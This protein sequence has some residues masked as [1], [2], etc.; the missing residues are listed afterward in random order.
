M[1]F[2]HTHSFRYYTTSFKGCQGH[3]QEYWCIYTIF[4]HLCCANKQAIFAMLKNVYSR[5][6]CLKPVNRSQNGYNC[7]VVK[8]A[9]YNMY[10]FSSADLCKLSKLVLAHALLQY[11]NLYCFGLWSVNCPKYFPTNR[12]RYG[13][14]WVQKTKGVLVYERTCICDDKLSEHVLRKEAI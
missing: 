1:H 8:T 13:I 12:D 14:L 2:K 6:N 9:I 10:K 3:E 5:I 4:T 11:N 7:R